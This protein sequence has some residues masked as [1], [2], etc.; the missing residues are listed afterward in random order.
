[1]KIQNITEDWLDLIIQ[2]N[3]ENIPAVSKLDMTQL[4]FLIKHSKY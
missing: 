2:L 3:N 1:M 4:I